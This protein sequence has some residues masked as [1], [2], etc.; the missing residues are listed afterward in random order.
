M[1]TH[2]QDLFMKLPIPLCWVASDGVVLQMNKR[3]ESVFGYSKKDMPILD[4][5]WPLAYPDTSYR[6]WVRRTWNEALALAEKRD[7]IP[8][9]YRVRCK[10]QQTVTMEISGI[11]LG[12]GF[13][14]TFIDVTERNAAQERVQHLAFYDSLTDLPN[15]RLLA[16]RLE[17]LMAKLKRS[18]RCAA[19]MVVDLDNF[20]PLN[21]RWGH[22]AGDQV[23]V[24][25]ARRM[26]NV[27]RAVDTVSRA[28]GDEFVVLLDE[29]DADAEHAARVAMDIARRLQ[30]SLSAEFELSLDNLLA[31]GA[32][33]RGSASIGVVLFDGRVAR[34]ESLFACADTAMYE[35]KR[36]GRNGVLMTRV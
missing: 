27:V 18:Q 35:V 15:R 1:T 34:T 9:E 23:L 26:V 11:T 17:H 33:H 28:G 22:A 12:D 21:D 5:W 20:K 2:F 7:I 29:I 31:R 25:A 13:L 16:T 30:T 14:A 10:N 24:E 19:L 32:C 4:C 6:D 36:Q 8:I 3:F